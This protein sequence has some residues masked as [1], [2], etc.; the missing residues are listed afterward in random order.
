MAPGNLV[1]LP[2]SCGW[3]RGSRLH[4]VRDFVL[5]PRPHLLRE[6]EII[7]LGF[8]AELRHLF[9]PLRR[10]QVETMCN[11]I[12]RKKD[13]VWSKGCENLSSVL[14]K[15]TH[16]NASFIMGSTERLVIIP[17]IPRE[18]PGQFHELL[19]ALDLAAVSVAAEIVPVQQPLH[20]LRDLPPER[21]EPSP[22]LRLRRSLGGGG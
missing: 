4:G 1:L 20:V 18:R 15:R 6:L 17:E 5:E 11:I 16:N 12:S 21:L 3:Q 10:G 2:L 14:R 13:L 8:L 19:L 22:G 7:N 9:F